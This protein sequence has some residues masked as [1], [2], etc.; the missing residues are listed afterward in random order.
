[1]AEAITAQEFQ[2]WLEKNK[3]LTWDFSG[4]SS[5]GCPIVKYFYLSFDTR[6]MKIFYIKTDNEDVFGSH[7]DTSDTV[8]T[9]LEER[10]LKEVDKD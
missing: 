3:N 5:K 10:I 2:D 7:T 9:A 1:M 4:F 6:D 8:L